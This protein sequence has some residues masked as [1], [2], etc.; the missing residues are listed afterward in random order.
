M[1]R[2][3]FFEPFLEID[4]TGIAPSNSPAQTAGSRAGQHMEH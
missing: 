1:R 3:K 2:R 4:L